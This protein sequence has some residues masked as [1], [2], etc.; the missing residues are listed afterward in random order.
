MEY[1]QP[2]PKSS[3]NTKL[4]PKLNRKHLT[5]PLTQQK[6]LYLSLNPMENT[7]HK[8]K[9]SKNTKFMPKSY[10]KYLTQA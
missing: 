8:R 5:Q 7:Q 3:K 2:K 4:K 9:S 1:T 10:R 6:T